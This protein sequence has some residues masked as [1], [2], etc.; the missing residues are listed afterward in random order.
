MQ[1]SKATDNKL[2]NKTGLPKWQPGFF[3]EE[4]IMTLKKSKRDRAKGQSIFEYFVLTTAVVAVVL[5]FASSGHFKSIKKTCEEEFDKAAQQ[6][7]QPE[8]SK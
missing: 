3:V 2:S 6:I 1:N 5:F 7:I 4:L 8:T